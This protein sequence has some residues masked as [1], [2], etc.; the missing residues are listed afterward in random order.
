MATSSSTSMAG[1]PSTARPN[2]GQQD[3]STDNLLSYY[4]SLL[5]DNPA[6]SPIPISRNPSTGSTS[7]YSNFSQKSDSTPSDYSN[8]EKPSTIATSST[9]VTR[10]PSKS[11]KG[12]TDRRRLAIVQVTDSHSHSKGS[13]APTS[14]ST[15]RPIESHSRAGEMALVAPPDV[16]PASYMSQGSLELI[17]NISAHS[18]SLHSYKVR[19]KHETSP[20]LPK[21]PHGQG[22]QRSAS[23]VSVKR[24]IAIIGT[25]AHWSSRTTSAPSVDSSSN[26]KSKAS[27]G[28]N[29]ESGDDTHSSENALHPQPL[30]VHPQARSPSPAYS[31]SSNSD[32]VTT[33]D[34]GEG[35]R[36]DQPVAGPV[37]YMAST[38]AI[39]PTTAT[40]AS[41][42]SSIVTHPTTPPSS[43]AKPLS[44]STSAPL[45]TSHS[46]SSTLDNT[47]SSTTTSTIIP[48]SALTPQK[49]KTAPSIVVVPQ[50]P[51]TPKS[52]SFSSLN[53]PSPSVKTMTS[54]GTTS[55]SSFSLDN[56][57]AF[58]NY[59]P[60][61]HSTAGPLPPP[62]RASFMVGTAGST[63]P[64]RPPRQ[65][66]S[67]S[68]TKS[69]ATAKPPSPMNGSASANTSRSGD[70][71]R[72]SRSQTKEDMM[73]ALRLPPEVTAALNSRLAPVT[74]AKSSSTSGS[75]SRTSSGADEKSLNRRSEDDHSSKSVSSS[76]STSTA[77]PPEVT[78]SVHTR[79]G[80]FAPS[81]IITPPTP[82]TSS[83][84]SSTVSTTSDMTIPIYPTTT[85]HTLPERVKVASSTSYEEYTLHEEDESDYDTNG[86]K[87]IRL[88]E[89][90]APLIKPSPQG[91]SLAVSDATGISGLPGSSAEDE[92]WVLADTSSLGGRKTSMDGMPKTPKKEKPGQR[93]SLDSSHS[94]SNESEGP[95]PPPKSFRNSFTKGLKRLSLNASS[96]RSTSL[97]SEHSRT[98][99]QNSS[100]LPA[101]PDEA[102]Y[103]ARRSF[104]PSPS[105]QSVPRPLS[106]LNPSAYSNPSLPSS[107]PSNHLSPSPYASYYTRSHPLAHRRIKNASPDALFCSELYSAPRKS[108]T[109]A[110]RCAIYARKLNE[111][112]MYDC[113]LSDWIVGLSVGM[114]RGP[115][116]NDVS[117]ISFTDTP[118]KTSHGSTISEATFP[119]RPD[120]STATDLMIP[121]TISNSSSMSPT[122]AAPRL[123]YPSLATKSHSGEKVRLFG[124]LTSPTA[125]RGTG[126]FFASLGRKASINR[127]RGGSSDS[128]HSTTGKTRLTKPRPD[129]GA[130]VNV[131]GNTISSP[132]S[133]N[134][135]HSIPGGPRAPP[136]RAKTLMLSPSPSP[137]K[138]H[139]DAGSGSESGSATV[140]R[141]PSMY[142]L[143]SSSVSDSGHGIPRREK[144]EDP[145]FNAQVNK[146]A[147][148]LPYVEKTVLAGYLR[149]AGHDILAIG[150]YLDDEKNGCV[151]G[152]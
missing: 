135:S 45:P 75:V 108:T 16:A 73:E 117:V 134:A 66:R 40:A 112:Y 131:N 60:G 3:V 142:N 58:R 96:H 89:K 53:S 98:P 6:S 91:Q 22:H 4:S 42:P 78:V 143:S 27:N 74:K 137:N 102:N 95:S 32:F 72:P 88:N 146:L 59:Q 65:V 133:V 17:P 119:R 38:D 140:G 111:L 10:R 127:H 67:P 57:V 138:G 97:S 116:V 132:V 100:T 5:A 15:S 71:G 99:S 125:S 151:R 94:S 12:A 145:S 64:P 105:P 69:S 109:S 82:T 14:S 77:Y 13:N 106:P 110:E 141:R 148:L 149:R 29:L 8:D 39:S 113:G 41:F 85:L 136:A 28:R 86:Q 9:S 107:L 52:S 26:T 139:F 115:S 18:S 47:P 49:Q 128:G 83:T 20:T 70:R 87:V 126:G 79:E 144:E 31:V 34:I 122:S 19:P 84:T 63:P 2:L 56:L 121:S 90:E 147:D 21:Q 101:L 1:S 123:P 124:H 50:T 51:N 120:A 93:Y 152:D 76:T 30:F 114:S 130:S 104:S 25:T 61:V 46:T 68:P 44:F 92:D 48:R 118:R 7:D 150:Q 24:D 80:A 129:G 35:K 103:E 36:I 23:E 33:P 43:A 55:S 62:P 54:V 11:S 81:H 37:V